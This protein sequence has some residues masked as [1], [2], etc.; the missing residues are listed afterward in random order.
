MQAKFRIQAVNARGDSAEYYKIHP[1]K[2]S[3]QTRKAGAGLV[4]LF[5][6][7]TQGSVSKRQDQGLEQMEAAVG[8]QDHTPEPHPSPRGETWRMKPSA[9]LS[10]QYLNPEAQAV[11]RGCDCCSESPSYPNS[12]GRDLACARNGSVSRTFVHAH[13]CEG[14]GVKTHRTDPLHFG[15]E[16]HSIKASSKIENLL[17][18]RALGDNTEWCP[19]DT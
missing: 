18:R 11:A 3:G 13:A 9:K 2:R 15:F 14:A 5:S 10:T 8:S 12:L 6:C 17:S 4:W 1:A 7:R 19:W 16:R